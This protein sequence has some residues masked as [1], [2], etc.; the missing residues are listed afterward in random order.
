VETN[1]GHPAEAD[2]FGVRADAQRQ[3]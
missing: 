3:V 2:P 1:D